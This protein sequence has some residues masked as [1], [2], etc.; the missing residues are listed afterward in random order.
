MTNETNKPRSKR[1]PAGKALATET[2]QERAARVQ[3]LLQ[4]ARNEPEGGKVLFLTPQG[5]DEGM[6]AGL[7]A[8][9]P[10][11]HAMAVTNCL[12][13]GTIGTSNSNAILHALQHV[14]A[15]VKAGD[16]GHA[17]EAL[18][19]Q[20]HTL[21]ALFM[22][23]LRLHRANLGKHWPAAESMLRLALKAQ[24][25]A[26][27]TW[28]SLSKIKNPPQATFI[29]QANL[30]NGPQQVNNGSPRAG[31]NTIAPNELEDKAH[32]LD[33]RETPAT[34]GGDPRAEAVAILH[35]AAND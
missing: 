6:A 22:E 35:G 10:S 18:V 2:E 17:E 8:I 5:M 28:E 32:G 13:A 31:D 7:S 24:S 11:V 25:Q 21:D 15:E 12:T 30:A 26:R 19:A 23:M 29:R 34:V 14:A 27:A 20:A 4:K 9:N 3:S 33:A 1:K 16:M